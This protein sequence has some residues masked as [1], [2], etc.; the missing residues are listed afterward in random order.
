MKRQRL[1]KI[2]AKSGFVLKKKQKLMVGESQKNSL[3]ILFEYFSI[4]QKI[5]LSLVHLWDHMEIL[6]LF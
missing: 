3:I 4:I 1:M 5:K 6:E 2:K